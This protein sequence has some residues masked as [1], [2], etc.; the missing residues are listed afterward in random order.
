MADPRITRM[1]QVLVRYSVAVK[2]GEPVLIHCTD[3]AAPLV[4]E[5]YREALRAGGHPE[6]NAGVPGL[7]EIFYKEASEAQLTYVSPLRELAVER[8]PVHIH[9]GAPHN[10]KE[11]A[12]VDSRKQAM[13][14]RALADLE[15]RFMEKAALGEIRWVYAEY[16]TQAL[17][18]EAGMSLAEYE[19]FLFSACRLDEPDPAA[20]WQQ[21]AAE[22]ER[23]CRALEQVDV[24]RIVAPDTDLT[25][26]VGGRKWVSA[27]GHYN[28]PDGEV[29]TGPVEDSANGHIRFS[30]PGIYAGKEIEDIRLTFR[31]GRVVE[32]SARRGEDLLHA[33]LDSDDGARYLGELGI[34]TNFQIQR[35]TR[36]MLFD[37]KIGGTIHLAIGAGYPETGSRNKSG[38]HWDMLCDMRDG[39]EIW[40]DGR[41]IYQAGRFVLQ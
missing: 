15:T 6:V 28:F 1:A 10:V 12:G 17:A 33:L 29:F 37:E 2:P 39:G 5:I 3:L 21:V 16:P 4:R 41:L 14:S 13:R 8:Y 35:F 26:R 32:A 38:V 22:Q 27:D 25:L 31:D 24:L 30:F 20:A 9:I 36:N 34:G 23:I 19:E 7:A 40:A 18:Q 11:L